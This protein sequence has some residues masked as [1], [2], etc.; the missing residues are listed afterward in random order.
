MQTEARVGMAAA[1][2]DGGSA[3]AATAARRYTTQQQ[4]QQQLQHHQPQLGTVP[5]LLAGGV[6][7]AVSKTCTA[8]L[9]RLTIL[10]QVQGMH[11]DV[12]TMRQIS[13]WREASR[14]VYEEG[15]RAFWKGNLVTIAHR[16]PYSSISFY[17]YERYKTMLQM[18]PGLEKNGGFGADVGVRLLG[19]GL[20]GITAASMTYPLDLVRTRLAA[21]TNTAY[22]RGI[23]H[24]LYAICRDEG[25]R[26]LYKGLGAT[27]L[28]VGP[29]IAVSFSVYE[30]LR[31]H[32]QTERP[33]DSPV[34]ISLACGSLSG[35]ASSTF[36][37]P[38]DLVRRRMQLEGA[39]GRARV[40]Q[41]G[42][43]FG[44]FGHIVRTEGFR[45]L[46]RGI[47]PEY[48]KVVPGVGIVFMTYEMLKAIL[49]GLESDD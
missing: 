11:S 20:S 34:L 16:L 35:I 30:T 46:Y 41:T 15:F 36:T 42:P 40:Y 44:T 33:C 19:G 32:W 1:T 47:L 22:Y 5:H 37:F 45:G 28:G 12:A 25:V 10:F 29:S 39:A 43:L 6:A 8:P 38:L 26:G 2:M 17:A 9:A 4:A 23:S 27:L 18:V 3:A 14:I 49:T 13:I 31:S 24:A 7:G 21:Q 48:C